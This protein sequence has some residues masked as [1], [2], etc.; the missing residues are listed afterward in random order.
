MRTHLA[1]GGHVDVDHVCDELKQKNNLIN[2]GF[3]L[4]SEEAAAELQHDYHKTQ[5]QSSFSRITDFFHFKKKKKTTHIVQ[6]W[7]VQVVLRV[8]VR[9]AHVVHC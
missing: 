6:I 1:D 8:W 4:Q 9:H 5:L 7:D 3:K 2:S